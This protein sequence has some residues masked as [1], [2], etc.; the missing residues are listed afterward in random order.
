MGGYNLKK[1]KLLEKEYEVEIS[2]IFSSLLN[3]RDFPFP[4]FPLF[5]Q[6]L[7]F[8]KSGCFYALNVLKST[9]YP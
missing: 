3:H 4:H 2:Q 7:V 9:S 8:K 5:T 1:D 6:N